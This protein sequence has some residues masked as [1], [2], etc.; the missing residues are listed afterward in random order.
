MIWNHR[1]RQKVVLRSTPDQESLVYI[2]PRSPTLISAHIWSMSGIAISQ[3][4]LYSRTLLFSMSVTAIQ[5]CSQH[6]IY[7]LQRQ[8]RFVGGRCGVYIFEWI[9]EVCQ[10]D[11]WHLNCNN[12]WLEGLIHYLKFSFKTSLASQSAV[13]EYRQGFGIYDLRSIGVTCMCFLVFLAECN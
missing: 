5:T 3:V 2:D 12:I 13:A 10:T 9:E 8:S 4:S 7:I 6:S 11:S 1:E